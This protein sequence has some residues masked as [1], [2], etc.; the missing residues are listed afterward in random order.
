MAHPY[1]RRGFHPL[2]A[3]PPRF[4]E[5]FWKLEAAAIDKF[6]ALGPERFRINVDNSTYMERDTW[7]GARFNKDI[8]LISDEIVKMAPPGRVYIS[9]LFDDVCALDIKWSTKGN[10]KSFYAEEFQTEGETVSVKGALYHPARYIHAE[11]D[12]NKGEFIHFDGALHFYSPED[13]Q[14]RVFS[15]F[16][17]NEKSERPIK[18][19]SQKLFRM[20][21]KIPIEIW[22]EFVSRF[23]TGDPLVFEYFEGA[24]P[25]H[26]TEMIDVIR[27]NN[28]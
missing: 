26:I 18:T 17:Y 14:A 25:K 16:N 15:D 28:L 21:G 9:F 24:Y 19:R 22:M 7:Y 23:F 27:K 4:L 11:F 5:L 1:F 20:D 10:I 12:L 6:L 2:A 3:F 13:Y 8:R